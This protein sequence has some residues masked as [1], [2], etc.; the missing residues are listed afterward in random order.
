MNKFK[1]KVLRILAVL[2]S[3]PLLLSGLM[4]ILVYEHFM[5]LFSAWDR[6]GGRAVAG[7]IE[8]ILVVLFIGERTRYIGFFLICSYLGGAIAIEAQHSGNV[9]PNIVFLALYW[10]V[11]YLQNNHLFFKLPSERAL[12]GMVL[13]KK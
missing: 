12:H 8:L 11:I 9:L 5:G 10:V 13:R 4:K 2:F 6:F 7:A 3:L 1:S